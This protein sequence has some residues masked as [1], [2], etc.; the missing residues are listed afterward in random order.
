MRLH[1]WLTAIMSVL[2]PLVVS[3]ATQA[4]TWPTPQP[5]ANAGRT[6]AYQA[7]GFPGPPAPMPPPVFQPAFGYQDPGV[8]YPQGIPQDFNPDPAISPHLGPNLLRDSTFSRDGLWFR[9][10]LQRDRE[11][12]SSIEYIYTNYDT[13]GGGV[14]GSNPA[15]IDRPFNTGP[16]NGL[17]FNT[18]RPITF[19]LANPPTVAGELSQLL[20]GPGVFP[21]VFLQDDIPGFVGTAILNTA[22]WPIRTVSELGH[23]DAPGIRGRWG[24]FNSDGSGIGLEGWWASKGYNQFQVGDG[25]INGIKITDDFVLVNGQQILFAKVGALPLAE[26][27]GTIDT[28]F[29]GVGFTGWTQKYDILWHIDSSMTSI[30]GNLNFYLESIYRRP[31]M[32]LTPY[33]GARYMHL[34]ETF[35]FHGIDSGWHYDVDDDTGDS[36][37]RPDNFATDAVQLYPLFDSQLEALVQTNMAGPEIGMRLDLGGGKRFKVWS[38]ASLGLMAAHE[39]VQ[40]RGVNIGNP[41]IFGFEDPATLTGDPGQFGNLDPDLNIFAND[42]TFN[43]SE[44]HTNVSP[45]LQWGINCETSL[46]G[47]LPFAKQLAIFGEPKL[48]T[49]FNVIFIPSLARAADS[50][51]WRGFPEHPRSSVQHSEYTMRQMSVGLEWVR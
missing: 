41:H 35:G 39:E 30:G 16:A 3:T 43:E 10:L 11:F 29:P 32:R 25:K 44:S 49:G 14:V 9:E 22:A 40:V 31:S 13:P 2:A 46:R 34:K 26:N 5:S 51:D 20:V 42:T 36:T 21:F 37:F 19:N 47:V 18:V 24:Y 48:T 45:V 15:P 6:A 8:L 38:Q 27:S 17:G 23:P 33:V 12:Y 7:P 4:Q 28:F 1:H 50:I